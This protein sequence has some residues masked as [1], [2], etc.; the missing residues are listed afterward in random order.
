MPERYQQEIEE[1][2]RQSGELT[3]K[4]KRQPSFLKLVWRHFLQSLGGKTWS[5]SPGRVMLAA[6]SLL[7]TALLISSAAPGF[8]APLAWAGLLLFIVGY[9]MFFIKP[10]KPLEKRWRGQKIEL[11]GD[12][13]WDRL[14]KK[15]G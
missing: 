2:L 8:V 1:I 10:Q 7:L 11:E 3:G 5:I 14:R 12:S 9:A 15:L 4:P 6:V 13:W